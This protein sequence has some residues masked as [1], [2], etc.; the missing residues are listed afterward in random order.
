MAM[1]RDVA[2]KTRSTM[3]DTR[4]TVRKRSWTSAAER[5]LKRGTIRRGDTSTWPG[6][7]GLRFT[8]ANDRRV[9]WKTC[10]RD[11]KQI[12]QQA[13]SAHDVIHSITSPL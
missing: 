4:W 1:F 9:R 13:V 8:I 6:R 10:E 2:E 12:H 11:C 7:S 5:S 3:R